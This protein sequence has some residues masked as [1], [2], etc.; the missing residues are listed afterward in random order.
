MSKASYNSTSLL[1]FHFQRNFFFVPP[2]YPTC[3]FIFLVPF[4]T[5]LHLP[6]IFFPLSLFSILLLSVPIPLQFF[7]IFFVKFLIVPPI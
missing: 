1:G 3:F 6:H 2:D 4:Q 5:L 7:Q